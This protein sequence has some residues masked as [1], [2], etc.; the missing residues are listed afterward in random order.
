MESIVRTRKV[1]GSLTV[2]LPK[3]IVKEEALQE[4]EL[5]TI[6]VKKAKKSYFGA[7]KGIGPFTK[8]D[9]LNTHE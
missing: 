5:V 6:N 4:G 2:T 8:E 9:E 7:A 1:G 3:E